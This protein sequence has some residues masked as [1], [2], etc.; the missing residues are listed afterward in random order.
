LDL[1]IK[2]LSSNL[3][4]IKTLVMAYTG[5]ALFHASGT[6]IHYA[7]NVLINQSLTNLSNLSS[8]T[9]NRLTNKYKQLQ[10]VVI[11][12]IS[13]IGAR[14]FNVVNKKLQSI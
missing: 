8:D 14:M 3:E 7:L 10:L 6:T 13:L 4:K 1:Y 9:L 2:E 12:E 11:N 5:N